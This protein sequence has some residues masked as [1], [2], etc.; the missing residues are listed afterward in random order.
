RPCRTT[1]GCWDWPLKTPSRIA[2][3][4]PAQDEVTSVRPRV[5]FLAAARTGTD[6]Q[7]SCFCSRAVA[8]NQRSDPFLTGARTGG[9]NERHEPARLSDT[10]IRHA[11]ADPARPQHQDEPAAGLRR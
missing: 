8:L 11:A 6:R 7:M 2:R 4:R 9:F 10:A 3:R 5:R 1:A